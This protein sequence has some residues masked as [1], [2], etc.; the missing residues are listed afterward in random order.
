MGLT[1]WQPEELAP[2]DGQML[3]GLFKKTEA[4]DPVVRVALWSAT[5]DSWVAAAVEHET[6]NPEDWF[7]C[8]SWTA[9]AMVAWMPLPDKKSEGWFRMRQPPRQGLFLADTGMP[10]AVLAGW[11]DVDGEFLTADLEHGLCNG[12]DDPHFVTERES[13]RALQGWMPLPP[14]LVKAGCVCE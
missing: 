2:R 5:E 6:E 7:F 3:L 11:N 4:A 13:P 9:G 1:N 10:W 8:S 12:L 14:A